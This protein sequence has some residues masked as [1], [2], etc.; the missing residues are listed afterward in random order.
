MFIQVGCV[1]PDEQLGTRRKQGLILGCASTFIALFICVY[2]DYIKEVTKVNYIEW[3]V[4]TVTASDYTITFNLD[5]TFFDDF[6]AKEMA[7]WNKKSLKEG[8]KD[9]S[10]VQSFNYWV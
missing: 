10:R 1:I 3:D 9:H 7:A 4:K 6:V 2:V 8:R 5:E